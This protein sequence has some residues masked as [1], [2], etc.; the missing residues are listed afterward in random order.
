MANRLIRY[1]ALLLRR[2]LADGFRG[3]ADI[4]LLLAMAA[5][6]AA[7]LRERIGAAPLSLPSEAV[8]LAALAGP[9]AFAWH[10]LARRRLARLAEHSPIAPAALERRSR[11]GYLRLAHVLAAPLLLAAAG[12]AGSAAG[13]PV[14]ALG[15]FI[16]AYGAGTGLAQIIPDRRRRG[17]MAAASTAPAEALGGGRRA[18]LALILRRQSFGRGR[19]FARAGLMLAASFALTLAAGWWSEG[20]P[21]ALRFALLLSPSLLLLLRAARLDAGLLAFLPA[22][23]FRPGFSA[24]AVSA[25]PAAS[26]LLASLAAMLTGAGL[27]VLAVLALLHLGFILAGIARAWLYPGRSARSVDLQLQLEGAGLAVAAFLLPPLAVAAL[28]W[29]LWHFHR[30]CRDLRWVQI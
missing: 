8:W 29:R 7:W 22:A 24:F 10:R 18:V 3:P 30:H 27:A 28:L 21:E 6:A 19:A 14:A 4:V 11:L 12:L 15:I 23:G 17:G 13:R 20:R 5:L 2:N 25:L 16:L 9:A 26:F 1:D